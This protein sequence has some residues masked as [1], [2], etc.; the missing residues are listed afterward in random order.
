[1][2]ENV[3]PRTMRRGHYQLQLDDGNLEGGKEGKKE[4]KKQATRE[5]K[6]RERGKGEWTQM[7]ENMMTAEEGKWKPLQT[8]RKKK[9]ELC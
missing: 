5:T 7:R 1:M 4:R 2:N 8:K 3:G 6:R 9:W